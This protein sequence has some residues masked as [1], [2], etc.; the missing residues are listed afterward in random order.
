ME[1]NYIQKLQAV[2][3]ARVDNEW[4]HYDKEGK[5]C[6]TREFTGSCF[7]SRVEDATVGNERKLRFRGGA[8]AV[9]PD[10]IVLDNFGNVQVMK[11]WD[12]KKLYDPLAEEEAPAAEECAAS[13][14]DATRLLLGIARARSE[15]LEKDRE[16]QTREVIG[17]ALDSLE[18]ALGKKHAKKVFEKLALLADRGVYDSL[19]DALATVED[20]LGKKRATKVFKR[21][22][23]GADA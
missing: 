4:W 21:L 14:P 6:L 11:D 2:R 13:K 15:A 20:V 9:D 3:A 16:T 18:R 17:E 1:K 7:F 5:L 12:F 23:K 22:A 8:E 19:Q 10:W